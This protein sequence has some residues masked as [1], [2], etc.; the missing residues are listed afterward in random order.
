M[1]KHYVCGAG[2]GKVRTCTGQAG[3]LP[4]GHIP[5]SMEELQI[6]LLNERTVSCV[7][8]TRDAVEKAQL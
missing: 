6:T 4:L 8:P 7:S 5:S 3:A 2:G 1:E